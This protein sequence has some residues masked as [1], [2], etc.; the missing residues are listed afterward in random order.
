MRLAESLVHPR[1]FATSEG[2]L[3]GEMLFTFL[4]ALAGMALLFA[5]LMRFELAAK[6]TRGPD[7]APAPGAGRRGARRAGLSHRAVRG[8]C[9]R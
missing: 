7:L 8:G 5:T 6:S 2:G 4:V 1:V 3:P 9:G